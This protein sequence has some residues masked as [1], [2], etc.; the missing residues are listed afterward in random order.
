M[1][2]W[3]RSVRGLGRSRSARSR[4][5]PWSR[6]CVWGADAGWSR[7]PSTRSATARMRSWDPGVRATHVCRRAGSWRWSRTGPMERGL[8]LSRRLVTP[9]SRRWAGSG[10]LLQRRATATESRNVTSV[11][12]S[13]EVGTLTPSNDDPEGTGGGWSPSVAGRRPRCG[14]L[15]ASSCSGLVRQRQIDRWSRAGGA[16]GE[17]PRGQCGASRPRAWRATRPQRSRHRVQWAWALSGIRRGISSGG[18]ARSYSR[19]APSVR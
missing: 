16:D 12:A 11:P 9:A 13:G 4:R 15:V 1:C 2:R 18:A 5:S 3:G 10:L 8:W 19:F 14:G 17:R 7:R 6:P